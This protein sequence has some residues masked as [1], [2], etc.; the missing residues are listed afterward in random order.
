VRTNCDQLEALDLHSFVGA[1]PPA[2]DFSA[3][4][5]PRSTAIF[6]FHVPNDTHTC[7]HPGIAHRLC[8]MLD[9]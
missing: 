1:H 4:N 8:V 2:L 7:Q 6:V 3:L 5:V 9:Q